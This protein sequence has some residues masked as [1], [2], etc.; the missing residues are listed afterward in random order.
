MGD[1]HGLEVSADAIGVAA[2]IERWPQWLH[3]RY[4]T[5]SFESVDSILRTVRLDFSVPEE[6]PR[7]KWI[8][9]PLVWVPKAEVP[10]LRLVDEKGTAV[11]VLTS[12]E[13]R[14]LMAEALVARLQESTATEGFDGL[15]TAEAVAAIYG[16]AREDDSV[17][18]GKLL[19]RW[20]HHAS[21]VM[22]DARYRLDVKTAN[23][24]DRASAFVQ[25]E[26]VF[27]ALPYGEDGRRVLTLTHHESISRFS[28]PG[29]RGE[30]G[31]RHLAQ[32][33]GELLDWRDTLESFVVSDGWISEILEVAVQVPEGVGIRNMAVHTLGVNYGEVGSARSTEI[34]APRILHS[35]VS[36]VGQDE[37]AHCL[38]FVRSD[39]GYP[40][41]VAGASLVGSI[42]LAVGAFGLDRLN[43]VPD[44]AVTLL[45]AGPTLFASLIAL[46]G[47]G[48]LAAQMVRGARALLGGT[49]AA[50]FIAALLLVAVRPGAEQRIAWLVLT[51]VAWLITALLS[52]GV[53][54]RFR[55][56]AHLREEAQRLEREKWQDSAG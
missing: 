24:V 16:A 51:V 49:A 6:L 17:S 34:R 48:R 38:A 13:N 25:D 40:A 10:S 31:R 36:E 28:R 12:D 30:M 42:V 26:L 56:V 44:A 11:M 20:K 32:R 3:R 21:T 35:R 27:A 5:I 15:L 45:L 2:A 47:R 4:E 18:G 29:L 9:V 52:L 46:P 22:G 14:T 55:Q 1:P 7:S 37:A 41:V 8:P 50:T 54:L 39:P 23:L 33:A 43:T 53:L 19:L